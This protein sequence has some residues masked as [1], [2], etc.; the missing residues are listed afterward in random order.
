MH[1]RKIL[2]SCAWGTGLAALLPTH[3]R[4]DELHFPNGDRIS[5][6][7]V[8]QS[9]ETVVFESP[10]MGK[11]TLPAKDLRVILGESKSDEGIK[12]AQTTATKVDQPAAP[13][14]VAARPEPKPDQRE[15]SAKE[16]W[17]GKLELGLRAQEGRRQSLNVDWRASAERKVGEDNSLKASARLLYGE[18]DDKLNTD[19]L[20]ASFRWRRELSDRTFAQTLTSY[21]R[22]PL[23]NIHDNWEQNVGAG[24]RLFK[25]DEHT[26]N[27][28]AGL[29]AQYREAD[30]ETS[31]SY[32]LVE[33]FQDYTYQIN[34]RIKFLQNAV[35]QY[36]PDGRGKF[37]SVPNQPSNSSNGESNYKV[38]F[39]STLQGQ[40]TDSISINLRYEFE[41]DNA[42]FLQADRADQRISSS[43]GYGF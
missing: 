17:K 18:Q 3:L 35:A 41:F 12:P 43:I 31:G 39:D 1:L 34:K 7:V 2:K 10:L 26:I 40:L 19:R 28:G 20:D 13:A 36:S 8:S 29:T 42:V 37:V 30:A 22:D 21:Y 9:A 24:L 4:A 38:R 14:S 32:A 5:G 25:S 23:K 11:L 27:I 15:A 6:T 16:S 33:L